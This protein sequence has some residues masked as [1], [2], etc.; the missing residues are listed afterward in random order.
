MNLRTP[1]L[2]PWPHLIGIWIILITL[3]VIQGTSISVLT[4]RV[5]SLDDATAR[6]FVFQDRLF[7][8]YGSAITTIHGNYLELRDSMDKIRREQKEVLR[9][10]NL[11]LE[12]VNES[13]TKPPF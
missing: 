7:I 4:E 1:I 2:R 9:V 11:Y 5:R 10:Y 13:E 8:D 3:A 6:V 12:L